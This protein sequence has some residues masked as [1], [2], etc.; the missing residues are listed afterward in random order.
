MTSLALAAACLIAVPLSAAAQDSDNHDKSLDVRSSVGDM[1]IG[2][3]AKPS[4]TGLPVYPNARLKHS[5]NSKDDSS[6]NVTL[7]TS[8]FGIKLVVVSYV[9][10]DSQDKIVAYYK[11]QLQKKYGK[12]LE[13]H[14]SGD[15]TKY[16]AHDDDDSSKQLKC[17]GDN[18]G[19]N[20][21]LKVGTEDNQHVVAVEPNKSG[22]GAT[23]ALVYVHARGKQGDI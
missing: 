13:C 14:S 16:D 17:D 11:D 9:S 3:D 10:D 23:F 21:E 12:V 15:G 1:H 8:A 5:D 18:K 6:A 7:F 4:D 2:G 19:P 20:I 22:S